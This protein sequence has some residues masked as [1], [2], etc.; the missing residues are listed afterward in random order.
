MLVYQRVSFIQ[1]RR[2]H[3]WAFHL[4]QS[5]ESRVGKLQSLK[6]SYIQVWVSAPAPFCSPNQLVKWCSSP[7]IWYCIYLFTHPITINIAIYIPFPG[8]PSKS[9]LNPVH[10]GI[11]SILHKPRHFK[12]S[13]LAFENPQTVFSL[14]WKFQQEN[15]WNP[16]WRFSIAM[17]DY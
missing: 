15:P 12:I 11:K 7:Q 8:V 5:A 4:A 2:I 3:L 1:K 13:F 14:Y 17:F 10:S 6:K 9:H 16:R